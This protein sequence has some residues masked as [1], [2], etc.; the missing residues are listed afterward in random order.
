MTALVDLI[1]CITWDASDT[2]ERIIDG[3]FFALDKEGAFSDTP[4]ATVVL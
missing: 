4:Q 2:A 1:L 3:Q